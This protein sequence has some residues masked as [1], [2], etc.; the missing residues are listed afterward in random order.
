[1]TF[2]ITVCHSPLQYLL[3][4][5]LLTLWQH[6]WAVPYLLTY[7]SRLEEGHC[8]MPFSS[9]YHHHHLRFTFFFFFL[10][11]FDGL[12]V[13]HSFRL[14]VSYCHCLKVVTHRCALALKECFMA[15]QW[16]AK[17]VRS[18]YSHVWYCRGL[19]KTE[20]EILVIF[21]LLNMLYFL[22]WWRIL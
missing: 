8:V 10:M 17:A 3:T 13:S 14:S 11:E 2:N 21:Q 16:S 15:S 22:L 5:S 1:M 18:S 4:E 7:T 20:I 12:W 6:L 9:H 19:A